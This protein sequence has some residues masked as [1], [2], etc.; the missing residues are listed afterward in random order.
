M[1][2][3]TPDSCKVRKDEYLSAYF[4]CLCVENLA[5]RLFPL[6]NQVFHYPGVD[7]PQFCWPEVQHDVF[8]AREVAAKRPTKPSEWETI[9]D[10]LST[11]FTT[12]SKR[13]QLKGRG[14]KERMERLLAK[15]RSDDTQALKRYI[16]C[17][18]TY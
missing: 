15:F 6:V 2:N 14:C 17:F 7:M 1:V 12:S 16:K 8:L 10:V 18:I 9:A 4:N 11:T 5:S 3:S 13:V